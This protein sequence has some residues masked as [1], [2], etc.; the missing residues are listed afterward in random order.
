MEKMEI[1]EGETEFRV[2]SAME[3]TPAIT[4]PEE[5]CEMAEPAIYDYMKYPTKKNKFVAKVS[6]KDVVEMVT[7]ATN[8]NVNVKQVA[9]LTE[10]E[11]ST[12]IMKYRKM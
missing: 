9:L 8:G 12:N 2:P 6:F 11:Q 5:D 1:D 3:E 4:V 10:E 7:I